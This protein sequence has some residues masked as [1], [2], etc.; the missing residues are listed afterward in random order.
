VRVV[1][2]NSNLVGQRGPIITGRTEAADEVGQRAG[3]EEVFL[4]NLRPLP[5]VV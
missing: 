3:D 2:L 4:K 5:C 1:E